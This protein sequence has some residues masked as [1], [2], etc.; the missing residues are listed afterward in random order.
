MIK[1][2]T[3][4]KKYDEETGKAEL[5]R[6]LGACIDADYSFYNSKRKDNKESVTFP[7]IKLKKDLQQ[8][9]NYIGVN[10]NTNWSFI[11][12]EFDEIWLFLHARFNGLE[13]FHFK[14]NLHNRLD[15][16]W[17]ESIISSGGNLV[18]LDTSD[19]DFVILLSNIPLD[20]PIMALAMKSIFTAKLSH[21]SAG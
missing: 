18:L 10:I 14:F 17:V 12:G 8:K 11:N 9:D 1:E 20:I 15:K 19:D 6:E 3:I 16:E 5:E 2:G 21:A 7:V 13:D 4:I